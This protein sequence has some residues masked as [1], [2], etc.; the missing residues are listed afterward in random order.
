MAS[1]PTSHAAVASWLKAELLL[2]TALG[3]EFWSEHFRVVAALRRRYAGF[4]VTMGLAIGGLA[5]AGLL[6]SRR[7]GLDTMLAI[8]AMVAGPFIARSW[9]AYTRATIAPFVLLNRQTG[10]RWLF[11]L[12]FE[13]A[14]LADLISP[15]SLP[16]VV[17]ASIAIALP[18]LLSAYLETRQRLPAYPERWKQAVRR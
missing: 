18:W 1:R 15:L 8:V 13:A 2:D 4:A 9:T 16:M 14:L 11:V 12:L 17:I 10:P 3:E 6:P 5:F 7:S